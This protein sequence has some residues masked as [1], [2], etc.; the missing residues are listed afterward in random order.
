MRALH[1]LTVLFGI[2][3][4]FAAQLPQTENKP[5]LKPGQTSFP[6]TSDSMAPTLISGDRVAS[7]ALYYG[8][9]VPQRG[10]LVILK[11]PRDKPMPEGVVSVQPMLVKRVVAV[12]GDVV[13]L[14]GRI[15]RVNG[16]EVPESYANYEPVGSIVED[17]DFG[18][19]RVPANSYFVLG[20]NRNHSLDSRAFG[21][22][23]S[24]AIIGKPLYIYYS[25]DKYRIGRAVQ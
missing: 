20:D 5:A 15:L 21:A 7:D 17:G 22:I 12:G 6:I 10:D 11:V 16:K 19:T 1:L 9:H 23:S 3:F 18:P 25:P 24:S 4:L 13:V 8:S 2:S 14:N